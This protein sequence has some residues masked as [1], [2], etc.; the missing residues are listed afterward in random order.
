MARKRSYI[1]GLS[2]LLATHAQPVYALDADRVI[3]YCNPAVMAWTG[4]SAD[5]LVGRRCDYTCGIR[6]DGSTEPLSGLCPPPEAF[7][8]APMTAQVACRSE[9][10]RWAGRPA[11][12][13]PLQDDKGSCLGV[14][15]LVC[16]AD[17]AREPPAAV[18]SPSAAQ[19][20]Q[21]LR[22]L[23]HELGIPQL[24]GQVVGQNPAIDRVRRQIDIAVASDSR[25]LVTGPPG[26][27]RETIARSIHY[28]GTQAASPLTPLACQVLDSELLESTITSF[29]A[30]CAELEMER[31]AALLL[32]EVDQLRAD[33]QAAL[34]GILS[35]GELNVRTIATARTPLI[36]LA[37]QDRYRH[38]LA[39]ALSTIVIQVPSLAERAEDIPLLAQF[40]L[41]QYNTRGETQLAGFAEESI[42]QLLAYPWPENV[43]ELAELVHQA[44]DASCGPIIQPGDLPEKIR[45]AVSA[46]AHPPQHEENIVLD[47]FLADI[48]KELLLRAS[49]QAKGNKAQ[50]AR[51]LGISRARLLRRLDHFGIQ[52]G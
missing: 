14:L 45:L 37:E 18:P 39:F 25:V 48:E 10:G 40:F 51:L 34:A 23:M 1:T 41:E 44:C 16:R 43:D 47:Q 17:C 8:G 9:A 42:D 20:H 52:S 11:E 5:E 6:S 2:R 28:G 36:E 33:A 38:D 22:S 46:Q 7:E 13:L 21:D 50:A 15:V 29:A 3:V 35:I 27:G 4:L 24:A 30:S 49:R 32:L 26:S 31:P 19:L 12:F